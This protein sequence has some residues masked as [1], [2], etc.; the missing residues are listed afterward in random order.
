MELDLVAERKILSNTYNLN[1]KS[2]D[3]WQIGWAKKYQWNQV[4]WREFMDLNDG[5][6]L[7]KSIKIEKDTMK[8]SD[9]QTEH[10]VLSK[11]PR[12]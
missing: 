9:Q 8:K 5:L 12:M 10:F 7:F 2:D 1:E 4:F 3:I 6:I 11:S